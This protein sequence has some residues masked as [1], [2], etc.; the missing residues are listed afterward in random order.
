VVA[1]RPVFTSAAEMAIIEAVFGVARAVVRAGREK[2]CGL[3]G[4]ETSITEAWPR[5]RMEAALRSEECGTVVRIWILWMLAARVASSSPSR[6][7]LAEVPARFAA[8]AT[9]YSRPQAR[10]TT[11]LAVAPVVKVL[12]GQLDGSNPRSSHSILRAASS[13]LV[14]TVSFGRCTWTFWSSS[15]ASLSAKVAMGVAPPVTKP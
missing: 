8:S 3:E 14:A 11:L 10:P 6:A 4:E 15:T 2:C 7:M 9:M 5:P 1:K 13:T 12:C